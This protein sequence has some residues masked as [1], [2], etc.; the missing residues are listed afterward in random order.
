MIW[1]DLLQEYFRIWHLEYPSLPGSPYERS[2]CPQRSQISATST[3]RCCLNHC[4]WHTHL[5]HKFTSTFRLSKAVCTYFLTSLSW[6]IFAAPSNLPGTVQSIIEYRTIQ[7][8]INLINPAMSALSYLCAGHTYGV[9]KESQIFH[10][11]RQILLHSIPAKFHHWWRTY[12]YDFIII[13]NS[14]KG[15]TAMRTNSVTKPLCQPSWFF[16]VRV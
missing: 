16:I 9:Q 13:A 1:C 5:Q 6:F 10:P 15:S 14:E 12:K 8:D 2:H 11:V 7:T 3:S 4:A